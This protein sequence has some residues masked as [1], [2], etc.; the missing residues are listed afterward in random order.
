MPDNLHPEAQA[1]RDRYARWSKGERYSRLRP[2]VYLAWQERQRA[3]LRLL[4]R[5]YGPGDLQHL[6]LLEVGC[7][8][9]GN[10]LEFL[11][12]GFQPENLAGLELIPE[13]AATARKVLPAVLAIHEG[14]AAGS[15]RPPASIDIVFQSLVFS[16]LLDDGYQEMLAGRMWNWVKP[17][18]GVLWYD[19]TYDN[20][21]NA[22]VR[23]VP[24]RRIRQLFPGA[25]MSVQRVTL[26]PPISR[27]VCRAG[28]PAYWLLNVFPFLRTHVVCWISKKA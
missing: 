17:G 11:Q 27:R 16:S 1:V 15:D 7:G 6:T 24:V 2:E 4:G 13:R 12:F 10:L 14:D 3:F 18:G 28:S 22:G 9:G 25:E 21:A 20:P 23:G 8:A 5:K 26:A 19:F